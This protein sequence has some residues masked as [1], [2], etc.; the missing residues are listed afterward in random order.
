LQFL[1]VGTISRCNASTDYVLWSSVKLFELIQKSRFYWLH[2]LF[3]FSRQ[4]AKVQN[5][6]KHTCR[7]VPFSLPSSCFALNYY[8]LLYA[9]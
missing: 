1:S 7:L 8:N 6:Q 2:R 3:N 4:K 9:L 5:R